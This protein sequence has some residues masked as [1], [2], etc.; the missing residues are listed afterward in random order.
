MKNKK[1]KGKK[2]NFAGRTEYLAVFPFNTATKHYK[3]V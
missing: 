1:Y 3:V 2:T